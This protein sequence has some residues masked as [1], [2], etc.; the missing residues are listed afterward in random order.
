MRIVHF[1]MP[2]LCVTSIN[3]LSEAFQ[4]VH[5]YISRSWYDSPGV[6]TRNYQA[7]HVYWVCNIIEDPE[8]LK[9]IVTN[10]TN[11]CE[12]QFSDPWTIEYRAS[13]LQNIIGLEIQVTDIQCKF[14]RNQ[15]RSEQDRIEVIKQLDSKGSTELVS[16]MRGN[17]L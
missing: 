2:P 16:A 9:E 12:S 17:E 1:F 3:T 5:D 14:K 13:M 6:P 8:R 4:G 11:F 15:N 7:V 10:L